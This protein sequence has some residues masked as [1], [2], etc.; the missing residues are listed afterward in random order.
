MVSEPVCVAPTGDKVG[1][2]VVWHAVHEAVYWTDITR[3]LIHRF[4]PVDHCVRTWLFEEPVTALVLTN[5]DDILAVV[6]GSRVILWNPSTDTR[7]DQGFRL[8][9]WPKVRLN[10]ARADPLGWLWVGSMRND[11]NPDGS[12]A[13]AGGTDGILYRVDSD[14]RALILRRDIGISNTVAW[15]PD[16]RLF[17]FGDTLANVIWVYDRDSETGAIHNERPFFEEFSRGLPDGSSVDAEG[18]LWNCRY[19]GGCIVRVAPRGVID[20]IIEMPVK[21][22]TTCT[23]GGSDLKTLYVTTASAEAPLGDQIG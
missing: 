6:L 8:A 7:R 4:T 12:E 16:G 21:N 18:Y 9:G 14:A 15:S 11:V 10:D 20:R 17:Y 1:E 22:I 5:R 3:F 13:E 23:F 2:G 19:Y